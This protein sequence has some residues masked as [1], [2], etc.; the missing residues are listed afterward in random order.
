MQLCTYFHW[1]KKDCI[2]WSFEDEAELHILCKDSQIAKRKEEGK[3]GSVRLACVCLCVQF[4][5]KK[6]S[7][8]LPNVLCL[9]EY[10]FCLHV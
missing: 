8:I 7:R 1:Y 2:H 4:G 9:I 3:K 10:L 6:S 5:S